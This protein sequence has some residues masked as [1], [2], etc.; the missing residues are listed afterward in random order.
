MK[1][2]PTDSRNC[3]TSTASRQSREIGVENGSRRPLPPNRA[4]GS[5]AHGSPVSGFN[6]VI[7]SLTKYAYY[8]EASQSGDEDM[9]PA[10]TD[11]FVSFDTVTQ[12]RQHAFRPDGAIRPAPLDW[13][14]SAGDSPCGHCRR[15]V[16]A[17]RSS[18]LSRIHFPASL[19]CAR[20]L[21][22]PALP[23]RPARNSIGSRPLAV[24]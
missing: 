9:R 14:G 15:L 4:C 6:I 24:L 23:W 11:S 7:G 13:S 22:F 19:P 12:C 8:G 10:T 18:C 2:P 3:Q 5:P 1:F 20:L 16:H 17:A 21:L